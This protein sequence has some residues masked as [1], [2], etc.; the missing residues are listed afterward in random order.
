MLISESLRSSL[1]EQWIEEKENSQ[2]YLYIGGWLKNGGYDNLGKFFID[3]SKEED[4]HALMIFNLLTDLNVQ[5][6]TNPIGSGVFAILSIIDIAEKFLSREIQTTQ[7]LRDI[8]DL[9]SGEESGSSVV[10][11]FIRDMISKQRSELEEATTFMD[12]A[13]VMNEWKFVMLWDMS[14]K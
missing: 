14:L 4:E 10:E 1:L 6:E 5:F 3:A 11:E 13:K 8:R 12:K 9:C 7:S 2:F